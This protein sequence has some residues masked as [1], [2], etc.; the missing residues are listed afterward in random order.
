M[1][2]DLPVRIVLGLPRDQ[3]GLEA[4]ALAVNTAGSAE[5]RRFVDDQG[6][7]GFGASEEATD[8]AID[9]LDHLGIAASRVRLDHSHAFLT[10]DTT[11][12][13]AARLGI[14]YALEDTPNGT[15]AVASGDASRLP[16]ALSASV[17]EV[18]VPGAP[19]HTDD[20]PPSGTLGPVSPGGS[21]SEEC[22]QA[23]E[24]VD[25]IRSHYGFPAAG[26]SG[27]SAA[28][29]ELDSAEVSELGSWFTCVGRTTT[30]SGITAS[31]ASPLPESPA[32]GPEVDLDVKLLTAFAPGLDR[33]TI[34]VTDRYAWVGDAYAAVLGLRER[35]EVVSSSIGYCYD[36]LT[37]AERRLTDHLLAALAASGTPVIAASGDRGSTDCWPS[38]KGVS[39]QYPASSAFT[40]A[41]GGTS[42]S[43]GTGAPDVVWNQGDDA[44]GGGY[45]VGEQ[46]LPFQRGLA[47]L[48]HGDTLGVPDLALLADPTQIPDIP[49][50]T[51]S[52]ECTWVD[53]GGTSAAAPIFAAGLLESTPPT[54]LP[55]MLGPMLFSDAARP[56]LTDV[57]EGDN[58]LHDV[59]CC[60]AEPGYDL[61]SGWGTPDF[62]TLGGILTG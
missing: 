40:T 31:P 59:G 14:S 48:P 57:T 51:D 13:E 38:S 5:F 55:G 39:T 3:E 29:V 60:E 54:A 44:G 61:T 17:R 58:D 26:P 20:H 47:S 10:V 11:A 28:L 25:D 1:P 50:C 19:L 6:I 36:G 32:P 62:S 2:E 30:L 18:V 16:G 52:D 34:V 9:A 4:R 56:A 23:D 15:Y 53:Y 43:T 33:L 27:R 49:H 37:A 8:K 45:E 7:A 24:R 22:A 42:R 12:G 21:P 41:V 35:P 46:P